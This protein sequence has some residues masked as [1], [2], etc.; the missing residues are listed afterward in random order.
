VEGEKRRFFKEDRRSDILSNGLPRNLGQKVLVYQMEDRRE[1]F[2]RIRKII[3]L[4]KLQ[5]QINLK[6]I[7]KM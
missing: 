4:K 1:K 2:E 6:F 5:D 3:N 7:T